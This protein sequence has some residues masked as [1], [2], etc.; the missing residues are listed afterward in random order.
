MVTVAL[1]VRLEAD[2]QAAKPIWKRFVACSAPRLRRICEPHDYL[3]WFNAV[4]RS[5]RRHLRFSTRSPMKP[6]GASALPTLASVDGRSL[7]R[8][9]ELTEDALVNGHALHVDR[10]SQSVSSMDISISRMARYRGRLA[11][12]AGVD[13]RPDHHRELQPGHA[14]CE[15]RACRA[16][17][18][19]R[20]LHQHG[21][22]SSSC[23]L[24]HTSWAWIIFDLRNRTSS[25]RRSG[26]GMRPAPNRSAIRPSG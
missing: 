20:R 6:D 19:L 4:R 25:L 5:R 1:W 3:S 11:P 8:L 17:H 10:S 21:R 9:F 14:S 22:A 15:C 13:V 26:D 2:N 18:A 16:D 12:T 7:R 24:G 23:D